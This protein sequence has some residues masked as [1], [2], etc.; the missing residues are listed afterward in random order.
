M[1][2]SS[3]IVTKIKLILIK[4]QSFII[5]Y[6]FM[7]V[8]IYQGMSRIF[9]FNYTVQSRRKVLSEHNYY[10]TAWYKGT[11]LLSLSKPV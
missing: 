10:S 2:H 1:H 6:T 8:L 9:Y 3:L 4:I 11:E 5:S 7:D